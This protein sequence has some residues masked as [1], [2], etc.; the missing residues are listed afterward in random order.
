MNIFWDEC[1][2]KKSHGTESLTVTR[3]HFARNEIW[4]E[5]RKSFKQKTTSDTHKY[6]T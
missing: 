4:K 5:K 3:V 1:S 6:M 2:E